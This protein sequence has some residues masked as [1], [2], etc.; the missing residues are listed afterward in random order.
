MK[1]SHLITLV[2]VAAIVGTTFVT[3][4]PAQACPFSSK[5]SANSVNQSSPS[6][7]PTTTNNSNLAGFT[8]LSGLLA[9]GG[10]YLSRRSRQSDPV[11]DRAEYEALEM[12]DTPAV[13]Q[14]VEERE[15][16]GSRK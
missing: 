6:I 16:V 1:P 8:L 4:S 5:L 3:S 14:V 11:I 10:I 9:V 2:S 12:I 7:N 13:E 15:L